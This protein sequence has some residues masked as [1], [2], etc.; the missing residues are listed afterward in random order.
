[1]AL[2]CRYEAPGE[3]RIEENNLLCAQI[4]PKD[5]FVCR[6]CRYNW[7]GET[8]SLMRAVIHPLNLMP[9]L[10]GLLLVSVTQKVDL[11]NAENRVLLYRRGHAIYCRPF[12]AE[13][14]TRTSAQIAS[15]VPSNS[16]NLFSDF[17]N[18][19]HNFYPEIS[20]QYWGAQVGS[21]VKSQ[22]NSRPVQ[23]IATQLL[24]AYLKQSKPT[25]ISQIIDYGKHWSKPGAIFTSMLFTARNNNNI[26]AHD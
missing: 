10:Q 25:S 18:T 5:H 20:E 2:T 16:H 7:K 23:R 11:K 3:V 1:M 24:F 14:Q 4:S 17:T 6:T 15:I 8:T 21:I 12:L 13:K 22:G 19:M 9:M 26:D